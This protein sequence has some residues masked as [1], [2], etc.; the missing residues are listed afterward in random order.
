LADKYSRFAELERAELRVSYRIV[1]KFRGSGVAVVAPHAGK[2]EP[3]TSE[4]ALAIAGDDCSYYLFEGRKAAGNRILHI[5][6]SNFDEPTCMALLATARTA[7]TVHGE[8]SPGECV[9]V[10]GAN[11]ERVESVIRE[12]KESGFSTAV[13]QSES[14]QGRHPKNICNLA[15]GGPGVQLEIS[16]GL[17]ERLVREQRPDEPGADP[18]L[19]A[20]LASAVRRGTSAY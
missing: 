19:M 15:N 7:I 8:R 1:A 6:S 14:L 18:G 12:L 3:G 2:I 17:R 4:I 16:R 20:Q 5:T 13:H 10:G 11:A 9:Y